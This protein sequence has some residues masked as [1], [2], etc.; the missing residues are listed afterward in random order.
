MVFFQ[1]KNPNIDI[2]WEA[3]EWKN[4]LVYFMDIWYVLLSFGSFY[5]HV[6][7][8]VIIWYILRS[9]GIFCGHFGMFGGYL[10][11]LVVIW[12]IL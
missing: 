3:L 2:F 6:V 10:V 7:Y 4:V 1:T 5:G 11:C 12:N 8:F 9:F